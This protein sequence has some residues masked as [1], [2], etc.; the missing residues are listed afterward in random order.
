MTAGK[1]FAVAV[2]APG[3]QARESFSFLAEE[4]LEPGQLVRVPFGSAERIGVILG[5]EKGSGAEEPMS[6]RGVYDEAIHSAG[7]E[8]PAISNP[9]ETAASP[10]KEAPRSDVRQDSPKAKSQKLKV[11]QP[12]P[13]HLP[14]DLL[15][16]F[17]R[18]ADFFLA[19]LADFLRAGLPREIREGKIPPV[20]ALFAEAVEN[21]SPRGA[22]QKEVFEKLAAGALPL[23]KLKEEFSA[24]VLKNLEKRGGLRLSRREISPPAFFPPASL[25][26]LSA[27]QE[28]AAAA[29]Q[30]SSRPSLL[31]GA[32]G[33]GKTELFLHLA[34]EELK[35][36]RGVLLLLPEIALAAALR[37]RLRKVFGGEIA[38]LHS[39]LSPG[40]RARNWLSLL[41]GE[42]RLAVGARTAAFAPVK[43]L[44]LIFIDEAHDDS[45]RSEES[46]PFFDARKVAEFRAEAIGARLVL[47][48]ATPRLDD[49]FRTG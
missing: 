10:L 41:H 3:G 37:E 35:E 48:S 47:A 43:N 33:S 12:L 26:S 8:T 30:K 32:T 11:A 4:E 23:A 44:G 24:A 34:A 39:R 2:V 21:F 38:E 1:V 31:L 16:T 40:E 45:L 13:A 46:R 18:S 25:P 17:Q 19:P 5:E 6:L 27:E 14:A 49:F 22:K 20:G 42:R 36:G 9:K 29:I 15:E 28:A 7:E